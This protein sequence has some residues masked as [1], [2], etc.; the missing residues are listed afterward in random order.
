MRN[1]FIFQ[2]NQVRHN[3][4]TFTLLVLIASLVLYLGR[5]HQTL[6]QA[7][8]Y[9]FVMWLCAVVTDAWVLT[10]PAKMEFP[11]K[12]PVNESVLLLIYTGLAMVGLLLRFNLLNW[13]STPGLVRL[14]VAVLLF[15]F[16]F[17]IVL[18]ITLLIKR[19]RPADLG[20]RLHGI[21]LAVPLILIISVS[22][23]LIAPEGF[24]WDKIKQE[25]GSNILIILLTGLIS[26]GLS[27]EFFKMVT[28]TRLGRLIQNNGLAW[29]LAIVTWAFM[30]SPK[31]YHDDKDMN[32]AL[33]G[34]VRIMP[35]GLMWSYITWRTKSIL[36]ATIV[37]G[38]N[39]WGLQNF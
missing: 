10:R 31:W 27:E 26:A 2:W 5:K 6:P 22:A 16:T 28:M 14:G 23:H 24:T 32:E 33:L 11:V 17:P 12:K 37:H 19:Y 18:A 8:V 30:H 25:L 21:L 9:L 4:L 35:I 36:P 38:T 34:A 7:Y 3:K 39:F 13:D 15:G 29:I 20:V 1:P